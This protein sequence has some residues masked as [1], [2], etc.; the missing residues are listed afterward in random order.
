MKRRGSAAK[1]AR[2]QESHKVVYDQAQW[3]LLKGF[4]DRAITVFEALGTWR[5]SSIIHGSVARGDVD[6]E[7]DIDIVI[8]TETAT[9]LVETNLESSGFTVVTREISQ[10]TPAHSPKAHLYLD[11]E[12]RV[13]VTIPLLQ[14]RKLET[15]FYKFGGAATLQ[16]LRNNLRVPGCTKR[17]TLV[18][19]TIDGHLES[20]VVEHEPGVAR[21]VGVS[22][23][24]VRERVRVLT[25]RD[26]Y[27][28]TGTFLKLKVP[29]VVTF[30]EVLGEEA[31]T[32]P[33]LRRTLRIRQRGR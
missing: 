23:E 32:N 11:P 1:P 10:A 30:E 14:L 22:V 2:T 24:I 31:K 4:R 12:Q 16:D 20:P 17:L 21:K 9:Q 5:E 7:S 18:E 8:P 33:A 26:R 19:P 3:S 29:E 28:R 6:E 13:V 15:E 25:R 27:G